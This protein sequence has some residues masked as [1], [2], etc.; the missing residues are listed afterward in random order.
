MP[1]LLD[2]LKRHSTVIADTGDIDAIA[3]K[4]EQTILTL[5]AHRRAV[6]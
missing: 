6:A 4:L 3:R 1:T 5:V 2:S